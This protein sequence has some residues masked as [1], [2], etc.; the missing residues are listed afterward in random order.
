MTR[1]HDTRPPEGHTGQTEGS[2]VTAA[3]APVTPTPRT[4]LRRWGGLLLFPA[5]LLLNFL[6]IQQVSPGQPQR[7]EVSYTFF[8]QQVEADNVAEI[9]TRADMVQG[10]FRHSVTYQP[11]PAVAIRTAAEFSTV[12][13]TFADPGLESL[14]NAHGGVINARPIDEPRN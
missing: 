12:V 2:P 7:T 5:L 1:V 14:L 13:P 11:D 6:L 10:T 3:N 8:K 4:P 9:S